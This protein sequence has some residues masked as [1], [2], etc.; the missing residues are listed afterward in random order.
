MDRDSKRKRALGKDKAEQ[1]ETHL[2]Y[3]GNKQDMEQRVLVSGCDIAGITEP[4][5]TVGGCTG[6]FRR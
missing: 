3:L 6:S 2:R 1:T 4:F 5:G